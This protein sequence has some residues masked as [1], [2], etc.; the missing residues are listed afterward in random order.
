MTELHNSI[1]KRFTEAIMKHKRLKKS[2]ILTNKTIDLSKFE[3]P[4]WIGLEENAKQRPDI[5][6]WV[7]VSKGKDSIR[8]RKP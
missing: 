2:E 8:T 7:D 6:Y 1:P 3:D 4:K 5:Q